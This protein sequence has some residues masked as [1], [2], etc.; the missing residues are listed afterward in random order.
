MSELDSIKMLGL[1]VDGRY[2][3]LRPKDRL[4]FSYEGGS[5]PGTYRCVEIKELF[6]DRILG[7][8]EEE[9]TKQYLFS[10]M[11]DVRLNGEST[12]V[13]DEKLEAVA[14]LEEFIKKN[15]KFDAQSLVAN[16]N[17]TFGGNYA[18]VNGKVIDQTV[19]WKTSVQR[20][21]DTSY[22]KMEGPTGKFCVVVR[23]GKA[24][25]PSGVVYNLE[26]SHNHSLSDFIK[27]V[28]GV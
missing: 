28:F 2:L 23:N 27:A 24:F 8:D 12:T 5:K 15:P 14:N 16:L 22:I 19:E 13:K 7:L 6:S 25:M 17:K 9:N 18:L 3:V 26:L 1:A 11:R 4:Y 21:L 10:K 20:V